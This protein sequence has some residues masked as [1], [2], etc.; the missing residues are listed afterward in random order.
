M[1]LMLKKNFALETVTAAGPGGTPSCP[2]SPESVLNQLQTLLREAFEGP[3]R[4]SSFT[5][6]GPE[7]G[8][9]STLAS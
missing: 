1:L 5:D 3:Q 2:I 6:A 7:S 8:L 9:N 4:A